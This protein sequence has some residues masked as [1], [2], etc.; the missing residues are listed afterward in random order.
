MRLSVR[1]FVALAR[2]LPAPLCPM[3]G[4]ERCSRLRRI[5]RVDLETDRL[6]GDLLKF[7][8]EYFDVRLRGIPGIPEAVFDAGDL[9]LQLE[10]SPVDIAVIT[11]N[12]I[13]NARKAKASRVEFRATKK[14][15]GSVVIRVTDDGLGIAQ[16]NVD[17]SKIFERGYTGHK[18]GTG[19]GLYSTKRIIEGMGGS[20]ALVGDGLR[21]D[22][23]I[24]L[25]GA[26]Q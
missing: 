20:I 26:V 23:E 15:T 22:F 5:F 16:A 4:C 6:D 7:F 19:L 9:S 1:V 11:D 14:G 10:F 3:T 2:L 25:S 18:D 8:G 17:P 24:V 12:L 13:D 21:A